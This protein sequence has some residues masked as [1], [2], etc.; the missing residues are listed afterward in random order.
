VE[1]VLDLV[2]LGT[3]IGWLNCGR[4]P[5]AEPLGRRRPAA[6][7]G[8]A[9]TTIRVAWRYRR[10]LRPT[11]AFV[12][13]A[14]ATCGRLTA[15]RPYPRRRADGGDVEVEG[16]LVADH[17]AAGVQG[18]VPGDAPVLAVDLGLALEPDP[19]VAE[20][21]GGRAGVLEVERDRLGD[22]PDGQV[23]RDQEGVLAGPPRRRSR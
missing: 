22:A 12:A 7:T 16:D 21:V 9:A 11:A 8:G 4:R 18:G 23:A 19:V 5:G 14:L 6:A 3:G 15:G 2:A 13:A 17:D 20:R 1:R 10:Q